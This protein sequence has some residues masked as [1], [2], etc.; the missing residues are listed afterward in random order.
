MADKISGAGGSATDVMTETDATTAPAEGAGKNEVQEALDDV[1]GWLSD[2]AKDVW[3]KGQAAHEEF[4]AFVGEHSKDGSVES[5]LV[6]GG[7]KTLLEFMAET[8]AAKAKA[9]KAALDKVSGG[10][11]QLADF[12]T[13]L[14]SSSA[15]LAEMSQSE[16]IG[17][18][19][20][21]MFD[22]LYPEDR[23]KFA[24]KMSPKRR[25]EF[26]DNIS[27]TLMRRGDIPDDQI[28]EVRD[29]ILEAT[30]D[31]VLNT[32]EDQFIDF[33]SNVMNEAQTTIQDKFNADS[34]SRREVL[35]SFAEKSGDETQIAKMM[36]ATLSLPKDDAEEIAAE[37]AELH[38]HPDKI[39]A[40]RSG[41]A[42]PE[43][44]GGLGDG[45]YVNLDQAL[46]SALDDAV[47]NMGDLVT[48]LRNDRQRGTVNDDHRMLA[49]DTF[50][51]GHQMFMQK[52]G[53][54]T[55]GL[56]LDNE[57]MEGL[58]AMADNE[59]AE[60][61]DSLF[62]EDKAKMG[63]MIAAGIGVS[64]ATGGAAAPAAVGMVTGVASSAPDAIG[65]WHKADLAAQAHAQGQTD[66]KTVEDA[67]DARNQAIAT[68][69]AG[70]ATPGLDID[71]PEHLT[72]LQKVGVAMTD[73]GIGELYNIVMSEGYDAVDA[74]FE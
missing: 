22:D 7:K 58:R 43:T 50:K 46:E 40:L 29:K 10:D 59:K 41:A 64:L 30:E 18:L 27:R 45:E 13:A 24:A 63:V 15:D 51:V 16:V 11:E 49:D 73:A 42:G 34:S 20:R 71:Q 8:S 57:T 60:A 38:G 39:D 72:R 65:A 14:S 61:E 25:A 31:V 2:T 4:E 52:L 44:W 70:L 53:S 54:K 26:T 48:R 17:L 3:E 55:N 1:G 37:L 21:E 12:H 66:A 67:K 62:W 9:E 32:Y 33:T 5:G 6:E 69:I 74:L 47:E 56:G 68:M 35:A 36:V 28:A 19:N 23:L